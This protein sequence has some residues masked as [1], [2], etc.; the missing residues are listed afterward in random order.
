MVS[1]DDIKHLGWLSRLELTEEEISKYTL[2]IEEIIGYL[3][4][5]DSISLSEIEP[6]RS[7]KKIFELRKDWIESFKGDPLESS[8]NRKDGFIKGPRLS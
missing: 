3:D 4:K 1:R 2:Q 7:R 6:V 5:L 8:K